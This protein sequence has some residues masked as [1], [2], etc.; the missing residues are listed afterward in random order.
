VKEAIHVLDI[1]RFL[2]FIANTSCHRVE[3][4]G[5][6][7]NEDDGRCLQPWSSLQLQ[8]HRFCQI[9]L[10]ERALFNITIVRV[11]LSC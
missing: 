7:V 3:N 4:F 10:R 8:R 11:L 6:P 9:R 2:G 5:L 1:A